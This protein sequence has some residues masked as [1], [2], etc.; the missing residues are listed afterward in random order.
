LDLC[1]P[2]AAH[3]YGG[4]NIRSISCYNGSIVRVSLH[5]CFATIRLTKPQFFWI[6]AFRVHF[7]PPIS[8]L[9]F[10]ISA[11]RA[12][13]SRLQ[14]ALSDS[15]SQSQATPLAYTDPEISHIAA[16]SQ[17]SA[18]TRNGLSVSA[19][20]S[21]HRSA[22]VRSVDLSMSTSSVLF[23][24]AVASEQRNASSSREVERLTRELQQ[25]VR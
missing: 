20:T 4:L 19:P 16:R 12:E 2:P 8:E 1:L 22:A 10:L 3:F 13:L 15:R 11:N 25:A 7:T 21:A 24:Q 5:A 9:S 23:Q 14:A 6:R 18:A 17:P